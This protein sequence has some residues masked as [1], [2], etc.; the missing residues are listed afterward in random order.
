MLFGWSW[1]AHNLDPIPPRRGMAEQVPSYR[2]E[3]F[4]ITISARQQKNEGLFWQILYCML[5]RPPRND[6]RLARVLDDRGARD[7]DLALGGYNTA[8]PVAENI[9][10][11]SYWN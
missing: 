5:L 3:F 6:V 11:D 2:Q 9:A 4:G 10:I 8:A 7:P 1:H